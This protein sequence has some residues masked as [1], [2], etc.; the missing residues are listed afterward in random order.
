[1]ETIHKNWIIFKVLILGSRLHIHLNTYKILN[2]EFFHEI[3]IKNIILKL[4][5]SNKKSTIQL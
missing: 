1:M 2:L 5:I 3:L 4:K